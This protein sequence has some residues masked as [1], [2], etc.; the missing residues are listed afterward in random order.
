MTH[1]PTDEQQAIIDAAR[2][3]PESILVRAYAGCAKSTTL[4]MLAHA[5]PPTPALALAFNKKIADEL[6]KRFPPHFQIKTMN[7]LGHSAWG[8]ALGRR[9]VL[10]DKKLGKIVTKIFGEAGFQASQDDWAGVRALASKAMM[11]GL[12]PKPYTQRGLVEDSPE[13]WRDLSEAMLGFYDQTLC[14]FARQAIAEDIKQGFDGLISFDD[15]IYLSTLFGGSYPRFMLVLVDEAQDLSPLNHLQLKKCAAGR[16]IVVGDEKQ[17]IYSF[18]GADS[19]SIAKIKALRQDWIELPLATTFRCPKVIVERARGHAPGFRAHP[20]NPEG[21]LHYFWPRHEEDTWNWQ[22]LAPYANGGSAAILCRNNAPLLSL[23]FKLLRSQVGITMLGRDIGKG[24]A[25]LSKK[26]LKDDELSFPECCA[27]IRAWADSESSM[28]LAQDKE[29]KVDGI[30]DREGCLLAVLEGAKC[31]TAGDLRQALAQLFARDSGKVVLATGHRAKG[32]EWP[33]V[34][35]LD[36][37]RLPSKWALEA[38]KAGRLGPLEQEK[39]LD[40]VIC[41]RTKNVLVYANL[42]DFQ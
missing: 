12:V 23:A 18:R 9:L 7:G 26:I 35:Y 25:V 41:T 37:F 4:E 19:A 17:A 5:L 15:Q 38:A 10:D 13:V 31:Q 39:N 20:A 34:V 30:R 16:L 1:T 28:A 36:S 40:Y 33:L 42:E 3:R 27:L 11:M 2:D 8:R 21:E 32:L 14:D 29:E 6:S 24:L 22:R